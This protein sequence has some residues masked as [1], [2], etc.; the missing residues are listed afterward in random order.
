[1]KKVKIK[2]DDLERRIPAKLLY[3]KRNEL[4]REGRCTDNVNAPGENF[5]G[6]HRGRFFVFS[7]ILQIA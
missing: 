7:A 5:N 1:M 4:I 6:S 3:E 2:L